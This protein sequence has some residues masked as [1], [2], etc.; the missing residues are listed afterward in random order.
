MTYL[1]LFYHIVWSTKYRE[2]IITS[3]IEDKFDC[4]LI[5]RVMNHP[6][7]LNALRA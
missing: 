2:P 4:Y 3:I 7:I 5:R 6:A 1:K